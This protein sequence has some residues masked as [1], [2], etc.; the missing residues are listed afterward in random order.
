MNRRRSNARTAALAAVP[1]VFVGYLFVY[2][3]TAILVRG[4]AP[5]GSLDGAPLIDV[6]S[7]ADLRGVAWFTLW[8]AAAFRQTG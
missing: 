1:V 5:G 8:Q 3:L 4:M 2:P 6:F 7:S